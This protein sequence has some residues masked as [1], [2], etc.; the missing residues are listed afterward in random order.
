MTKRFIL[1]TVVIV[2]IGSFTGFAY[3]NQFAVKKT[4]SATFGRG[5]IIEYRAHYGFINAAVG[6]MIISDSVYQFNGKKCFKIDVFGESVG[7]FDLMLR[8]RDNWG[9]YLDT[10][11]MI[12]QR[13]WRNI[14][15]GKYRKFEIVDF[16]QK[17]Q[18]AEVVTYDFKKNTWKDKKQFEIPP[19]CQDLVS[20]YYYLRTMNLKSLREGEI[21]RL[22]GFFDDEVYKFDIRY[23]G[24]EEIKTKIGRK[25]TYVFSPI[26]PENSLF[27][28]ED[29]IK[30][31][32]SADDHKIPLKIRAEMFVGAVE[33]DITD[34]K[35]SQD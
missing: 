2:L 20:G 22:T 27:D 12:P 28:G 29:S 16:D 31:W 33:I 34:Y 14:R 19:R 6:K 1:Y 9:T 21:L 17:Q 24:Q 13:F 26:M 7:M 3:I 4:S 11:E 35:P 25:M 23:I 8:I 5:E 10:S 30:F 32:L 15:E 18:E